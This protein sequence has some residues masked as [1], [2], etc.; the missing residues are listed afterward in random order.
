MSKKKKPSGADT[1]KI[2]A[3]IK[4]RNLVFSNYHQ[5]LIEIDK[6]LATFNMAPNGEFNNQQ[7][8]NVNK[9]GEKQD[10]AVNTDISMCNAYF[11]I[12]HQFDAKRI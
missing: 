3:E 6:L 4:T 9:T 12:K 5:Q 10:M 11:T 8:K 2:K 7:K 1:E